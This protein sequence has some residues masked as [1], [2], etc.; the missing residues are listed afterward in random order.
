MA[1]NNEEVHSD[2]QEYYG[3]ELKS[4]DDLKTNA[5][6]TA[7]GAKMPQRVKQALALCHEEVITKLVGHDVYPTNH[8]S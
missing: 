3:K 8:E 2:V 6:C 1:T 5:C 7:G 4:K